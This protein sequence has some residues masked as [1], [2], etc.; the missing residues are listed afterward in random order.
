MHEYAWKQTYTKCTKGI[1]E[2]KVMKFIEIISK[3]RARTGE[4]DAV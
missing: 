4:G 3:V 1:I 2:A